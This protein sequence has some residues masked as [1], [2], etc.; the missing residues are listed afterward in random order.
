[1]NQQRQAIEAQADAAAD[2]LTG[3]LV[4]VLTGAGVSTDSGIPDYRGA[5]A[6]PRRS[7]MTFERFVGDERARRRYWAGGHLGWRR[8]SSVMPNA[9]H[10]ALAELEASGVTNGVITQNVDG[11]HVRAGSTRVIDL[12]GSG[13]RVRCLDCGQMFVRDAIEERIAADNPWLDADG[14]ST[15]NPDGD[16]EITELDRFVVPACTVCGGMLKPDVVFFGE[17]VPAHRF[18]EARGLVV[19]ADALLVAGTSLAVNSGIRVL[20]IARRAHKPIV[21]VN[22]GATKGDHRASLKLD[23]GAGEIL[24]G[25][26]D[27]LA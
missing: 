24:L 10:F 19:A 17:L 13:F 12:H 20:E 26:R 21:I 9:A 6:P 15:L 8:F 4:A 3:R 2:L 7:P 25:L 5:G 14:A 27:R 22:R 1:M 18:E 23:A 16:V 11:L